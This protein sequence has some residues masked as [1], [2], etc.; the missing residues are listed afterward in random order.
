MLDL[1][2]G[3][4]SAVHAARRQRGLPSHRAGF[5]TMDARGFATPYSRAS[6]GAFVPLGESAV[7]IINHRAAYG[8]AGFVLGVA[9]VLAATA[10]A[11]SRPQNYKVVPLDGPY[12]GST[13]FESLLNESAAKGWRLHS[14]TQLNTAYV[15]LAIFQRN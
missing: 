14:V 10:F 1:S 15:P 8:L 2:C 13:P 3:P 11:Q 4:R 7:S 9:V 5:T 12:Q 6:H